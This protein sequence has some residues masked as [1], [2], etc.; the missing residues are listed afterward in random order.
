VAFR[1]ARVAL[2]VV[3]CCAVNSDL[4]A[5]SIAINFTATSFGGGPYPILASETA[6]IVPQTNWNNT[7][8]TTAGT[9]AQIAS[10]AA[11]KL[12]NNLGI[13]SGAQIIWANG[14]NAVNSDGGKIT[15]DERLYKGTLE[16]PPFNSK[17]NLSVT[18]FNIPYSHYEVIAYLAGFG[19][20]AEASA[21]LGSQ[22]FFY[23]QSS[24]FTTDGYIQATATSYADRTLATYA[25]FQNQTSNFFT[26]DLYTRGGNRAAIAGLQI[27][28]IPEPS[29]FALIAIGGCGLLLARRRWAS[30]KAAS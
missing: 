25:V 27:L 17:A 15:P 19:F 26:L 12:V 20:S 22:E 7:Q 11:G 18:V 3:G 8:P 16:G 10:P 13:D 2:F 29:S 5:S 24:N 6:G 23:V 14:N 30:R 9:N 4:F 1:V 28:Q 21:K